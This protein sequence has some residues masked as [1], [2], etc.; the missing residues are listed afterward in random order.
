MK[1]LHLADLH[2]GK[3][4]GGYSLIEDQD[5]ILKEILKVVEE[6]RVDLVIISGDI[7]DKAIPSSEALSLYSSFIEELAFGMEKKIIAIAGNHDS[8]KRL[9][10]NS[11]FFEKASYYIFGEYDGRV[12][13]LE[14]DYGP[15]HFYPLPYM[16][17]A[18]AREYFGEE[19]SSF[20]EIYRRLLDGVDYRDRNVLITHCYATESGLEDKG[21]S[22]EGEKPFTIGGSDAMDAHLFLDFDY[23]ALGHLHRKGYVLEEKIRYPG[24]FMKYSLGER[25]QNKTLTLVNLTDKLEIYERQIKTLRDLRLFEGTFDQALSLHPSD[26]YLYFSLEDKDPVENPMGILKK[27]FPHAVAIRYKNA[28]LL[29]FDGRL[30]LDLE[31]KDEVELFKEFYRLKMGEDLTERDLD[32][33]RRTIK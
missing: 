17:L 23:V 12:V 29:S 25:E 9:S 28:N 7:F 13:T 32:L 21:D 8:G 2:L 4:L 20:T 33:L 31:G 1:I 3:D 27:I 30:D 18:K 6:E 5:Y 19:V 11:G 24:T 10:Y 16:S 15:I 22:F 26:D 14:D